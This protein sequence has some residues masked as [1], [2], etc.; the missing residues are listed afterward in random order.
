MSESKLLDGKVALITGASRGIG[1]AIARNLAAMGAKLGLCARDP[2][3][4]S[5]VA[6]EFER[7]GIS[8]AAVPADLSRSEGIARLVEKTEQT[9]GPVEILVNNAGIGYFGPTH[10]ASEANW[11]T[12][13]DTNLKSVFLLSRAVA[14]GMIVRRAGHIVNVA[15]LAGKNSF[16][17]GGIYCASKWGLL[18]LTECM[19]EDL[20]PHG[21]RV[22]AI[23]PGSVATDFS[24]HGT[25]DPRKMLQPEDV[26]HA[27]AMI[28]TQAPQSFISEVVLRPTQKP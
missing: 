22:S 1:L 23:C 3:R 12:V 10:E 18:G 25:K 2:K 8:V 16:A 28:L 6:A 9:L 5:S 26:A 7:Q 17:G 14:P 27:V 11:D 15:S 19:A 20:R 13:L 24:P 21:I 4:L